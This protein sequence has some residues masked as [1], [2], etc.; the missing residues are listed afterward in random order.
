MPCVD[1]G[2][3]DN[4]SFGGKLILKADMDVNNNTVVGNKSVGNVKIDELLSECSE[5]YDNAVFV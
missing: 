1:S 2:R 4:N 3:I 5:T